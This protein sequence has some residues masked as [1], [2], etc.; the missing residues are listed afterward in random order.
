MIVLLY[1]HLQHFQS[2]DLSSKSGSENHLTDVYKQGL[3]SCLD[4]PC[5]LSWSFYRH[6]IPPDFYSGH[7]K[8]NSQTDSF[9]MVLLN[10]GD[11]IED[12]RN[13]VMPNGINTR[14]SSSINFTEPES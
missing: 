5:C 13:S 8:T 7:A 2:G 10:H 4:E 14:H 6:G 11:V 3:S 12:K 1:L 9:S